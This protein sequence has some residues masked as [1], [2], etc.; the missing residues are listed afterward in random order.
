MRRILNIPI[1]AALRLLL[2]ALMLLPLSACNDN[3]QLEIFSSNGG[4]RL[5]VGNDIPF[6]Y[7]ANSCQL[8]WSRDNMEFRANTDNMSD[9]FILQF[10]DIPSAVG[11][12]V[13][14]DMSWTT[15][16]DILYKNDVTLEIVKIEGDMIWLWSRAGR[17]GAC[18]RV[19]D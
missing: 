13:V 8:V 19:L 9:Y 12:S 11:Q 14:A 4:V 7:E 6:T 5:Q 10:D 3:R 16:S 18:I 2:V 17:I 15:T 1:P